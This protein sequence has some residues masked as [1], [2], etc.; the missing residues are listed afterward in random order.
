VGLSDEV[1]WSRM[2]AGM[3]GFM[4]A[5]TDAAPDGRTVRL[6][7]VSAS[8]MPAAPDRSVI[9]CVLYD[10]ASELERALPRLAEEYDSAGV[11]AWTVW[12]PRGE[13]AAADVLQR[14]GHVL[15][16][17][18]AAMALELSDL[19]PAPAE[20]ELAAADMREVGR[21]ND[22]A[23]GT[24]G[25]FERAFAHVPANR[26][27]VYAAAAGACVVAV[28]VDGDCGIYWVATVPSARGQGLA[29]ALMTRA[30]LDARERGCTTSS[31]QATTLGRPVYE[32]LG[33]RNLG[34]I[35]MWERR[36]AG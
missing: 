8:L 10:D 29:S 6:G 13:P 14:A 16:A 17:R 4:G 23:Y 30:L 11:R 26:F 32:R 31:L 3:R 21:L 15:D 20:V 34:E 19:S 28:D 27:Q 33:Y 7:G 25:D 1:L 36:R 2:L 9:N 35:Q 22:G 18:P 24:P 12:V 5:L